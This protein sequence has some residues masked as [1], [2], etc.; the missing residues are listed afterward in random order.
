MYMYINNLEIMYAGDNSTDNQT[1]K[2]IHNTKSVYVRR[3]LKWH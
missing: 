2:Y 1:W 3:S